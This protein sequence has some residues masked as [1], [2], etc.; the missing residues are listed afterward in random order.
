LVFHLVVSTQELK[1][2][3]KEKKNPNKKTCCRC[4]ATPMWGTAELHLE[5]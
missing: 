2:K 1:E 3:E 5:L 4:S